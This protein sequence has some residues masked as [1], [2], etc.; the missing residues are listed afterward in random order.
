MSQQPVVLAG[1][2][3][4]EEEL[5]RGGMARVYRGTDTVLG[6]P[7]AIK[8]LAPQFAEDADFV[9]R[10]RREAQA[11]ARLNHPNL[12][13]VYDTGSDKGTHFIV[14]EFVDGRTLADFLSGG[15]RVLPSRAIEIADLVLRALQAAH[16]QGVVHR[17]IKPA[18][19]MITTNGGV[20]VTDFG[21]ARVSSSGETLAA[22]STVL[23]TASYLSPEQA[24][25][26]V[27]DERA[28]LY[29]LGCVLYEMVTGRPPFTGDSAVSVA[30]KHVLE[31]PVPPSRINPEV[32]RDLDAVILR[33]LEK[34]PNDRYA[35]DRKSTRLN[36]SHSQQSRMPSSA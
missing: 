21:I 35:S 19:I 32:T 20:K 17:D 28:D 16:A 36:S 14:M 22:T 26:A 9:A 13:S 2:Y 25:S 4:I 23:G 15:A 3:R 18:N 31:M 6:R 10:F 1:R 5:G 34:D 24:R 11:A 33:A 7:V 27:V 12:V 29:A 30:S 8:V